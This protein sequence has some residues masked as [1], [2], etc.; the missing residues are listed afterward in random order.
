MI[1]GVWALIVIF[2]TGDPLAKIFTIGS[3]ALIAGVFCNTLLSYAV[4]STWISSMP[5]PGIYLSETGILI[6]VIIFALGLGYRQNRIEK[7]KQR[8]GRNV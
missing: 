5:F 8:K 1:V 3:T 7:E 2:R 6:E 4:D